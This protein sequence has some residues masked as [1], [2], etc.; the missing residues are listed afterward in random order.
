MNASSRA[1]RIKA[2]EVESVASLTNM[3]RCSSIPLRL[4]VQLLLNFDLL[5][6]VLFNLLSFFQE[7]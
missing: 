4:G 3:V 6:T 1:Q 2:D 7:R 5:M